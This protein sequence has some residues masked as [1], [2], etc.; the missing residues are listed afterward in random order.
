MKKR[1]ALALLLATAI[2]G[3]TACS[4]K[5]AETPAAD[6]SAPATETSEELP[7]VGGTIYKFDD[8]FMSYVRRGMETYAQDK[9]NLELVDS[10]NNQAMQGDQVD[11]FLAKG[12]KALAINLVDPKAAPSI[13]DKASANNVPVIFFN[14]EPDEAAM[15]SYDKVWFVGTDS[16]ESGIIQGQLV[17]EAWNAN[18]E[19]WD[20]NADGKI[21]Y[22]MLKGEPGHPDAEARTSFSVSTITDAGIAVEELA[23]DTGMW[24]AAK[25][26]EK[27][28]AW[29]S[30]FG[31]KIEL[32]LC[33]NDGMALGSIASLERAGYVDDKAVPVI[34]VDAI[35]EALEMIKSGKMFGTVLND[36]KNQS[37]ATVELARNVAFGK[38]P[39][40]GTSWKFDEKKAVRVPYI[41]IT[42][43]NLNIAE[44]TYQ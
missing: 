38:D 31:D 2:L 13:I 35:P 24:D 16:K 1:T 6:G 29:I 14:K 5:P 20:K 17:V 26:T 21:Q 9:I 28:D 15:N 30:S 43:D 11:T 12:A 18:K 8:N 34:G 3:T 40:D 41:A 22:V 4:S 7:F 42:N 36:S 10:Q 23:V 27:M 32:V 33:N 19:K 25:A 44:E 39:L 37:K